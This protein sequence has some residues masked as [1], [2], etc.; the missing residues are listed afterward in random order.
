MTTPDKYDDLMIDCL[1]KAVEHDLQI[2]KLSVAIPRGVKLRHIDVVMEEYRS[3]GWQ[4]EYQELK[5]ERTY[6]TLYCLY[7]KHPKDAITTPYR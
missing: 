2:S 4:V 3:H 7:F 1:R 5:S 6:D